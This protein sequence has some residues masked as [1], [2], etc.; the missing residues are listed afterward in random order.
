M[1]DATYQEAVE[2]YFNCPYGGSVFVY[3]N[4]VRLQEVAF[5][6]PFHV[7]LSHAQ[8]ISGRSIAMDIHDAIMKFAPDAKTTIDVGSRMGYFAF[9]QAEDGQTVTTVEMSDSWKAIKGISLIYGLDE[10]IFVKYSTIHD[11]IGGD[12]LGN[13]DLALL[14][15]VFDHMW[16][17]NKEGAWEDLNKLSQICDKMV[18]MMGPT[19]DTPT[20]GDIP[21]MVLAHTRYKKYAALLADSYG[22]RTLW[23]FEKER[24]KK[25]EE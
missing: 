2:H 16:R 24:L 10:R 25:W 15:N 4:V 1:V 11:L 19:G 14:L 23:G 18:L 17:Q 9:L 22:G 6:T 20:Q 7:L 13:F 21:Q 8:A 3:T 5:S 12:A